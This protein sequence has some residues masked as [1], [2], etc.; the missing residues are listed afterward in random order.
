MP[1]RHAAYEIADDSAPVAVVQMAGYPFIHQDFDITLGFAD[2]DQHAGAPCSVV[3]LLLQKLAPGQV[4][5]TPM[6]HTGRDQARGDGRYAK[7][8]AEENKAGPLQHQQGVSRQATIKKV[9]HGRHHQG[10]QAG[11]QQ[12]DVAVVIGTGSEHGDDFGIGVLFGTG[13]RVFDLPLL[14]GG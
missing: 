1:Q 8:Q 3:Q 6:P 14:L 5:G 13:D 9:H 11:P 4:A 10:D 12:G 7:D 2:K